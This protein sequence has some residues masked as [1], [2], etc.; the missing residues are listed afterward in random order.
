M[1]I[2]ESFFSKNYIAISILILTFVLVSP[3]VFGADVFGKALEPLKGL[4]DIYKN[5]SQI[6][7]AI[8]YFLLFINASK[9]AFGE[10]FKESNVPKIMGVILA[11]GMIMFEYSSSFRLGTMFI[12]VA[13]LVVILFIVKKVKSI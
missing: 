12:P 10:K 9:D 7:D 4:G 2:K 5:N 8:L 3:F 11:L 13:I 6:I 1:M